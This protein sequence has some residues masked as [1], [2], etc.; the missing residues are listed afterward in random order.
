MRRYKGWSH[1]IG[2]WKYLTIWRTVLPVSPST[3]SFISEKFREECPLF[4]TPF[5]RCWKSEHDLILIEV[6]GKCQYVGDCSFQFLGFYPCQSPKQCPAFFLNN[7][8]ILPATPLPDC[9]L[10]VL[11]TVSSWIV[12]CALNVCKF[13]PDFNCTR[14]WSIFVHYISVMRWI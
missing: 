9:F 4:W 7:F 11:F 3:Q 13:W 14:R 10:D 2:S 6:D 8:M 5:R 12:H 1:K